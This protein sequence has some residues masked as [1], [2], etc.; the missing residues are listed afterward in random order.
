MTL[1]ATEKTLNIKQMKHF[2]TRRSQLLLLSQ[3][4]FAP[5]LPRRFYHQ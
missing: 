5:S 1:T 4:T 2:C 3:L